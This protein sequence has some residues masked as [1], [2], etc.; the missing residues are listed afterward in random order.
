MIRAEFKVIGVIVLVIV[1]VAFSVHAASTADVLEFVDI[2]ITGDPQATID[3]ILACRNGVTFGFYAIDALAM[4]DDGPHQWDMSF[5]DQGGDL[6]IKEYPLF[7]AESDRPLVHK[8]TTYPYSGFYTLLFN[9]RVPA[10]PLAT[11]ISGAGSGFCNTTMAIQDCDINLMLVADIAQIGPE[12][13]TRV[14]T[15]TLVYEVRAYDPAVGTNNGDGISQVDMQ[16][17]NAETGSEV[18]SNGH[19]PTTASADAASSI[20]ATSSTDA[21]S[22][23]TATRY[24]AFSDNCSPWVFAEHDNTW[25]N[26]EPIENGAYLLRAIVSTADNTRKVVQT[27]IEIDAPPNLKTVHVPAGDFQMGSDSGVAGEGP[28]HTVSTNDFWIM[29]TEVTNQQ[30]AQCVDAGACTQPS[31]G[32]HWSDPAYADHPVV[33]VDWNQANDFA[34][35]AGGRLP[36]EAEWEKA[37]RDTDGRTY[38]WGNDPATH[39]LANYDNVIGDTT[40]VGSYPAGASPYGALDMGGNVWEWTSSL[41]A[42]YPYDAGDG[43]EDPSGVGRRIAR[44]GSYFYTHYQLACSTRL[45]SPPGEGNPQ[46]GFR[47]AFDKPM[48]AEGVHFVKPQNGETV[49]TEFDVEMAAQG[50]TIEP[51]GEIHENAGHFHIL[52]DSDFVEP[53]GLVPFD[54]NHLHFGQGQ[55]TAT[56]DLTPGV[57]TLRLQVA[58]G[59]HIALPGVQYRD[60]ITVTVSSSY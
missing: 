39:D 8:G 27:Q 19:S 11:C 3:P 51:A 24:C 53:G 7:L 52:V 50:I 48:N 44:G 47:V 55:T 26:G 32:E 58:N 21:I 59:A 22:L 49:P 18:Y 31:E 13:T 2:P 12:N 4:R 37:C 16:I 28:L 20:V 35:W 5:A 60:E 34:G 45:P 33:G 43:R 30:Y 40:P 36:T 41:E 42:N 54:E 56:L 6:L 9:E 38:P 17:I 25:P 23:T 10:A 14:V 1:A 29:T 46:I 15:D 57:H